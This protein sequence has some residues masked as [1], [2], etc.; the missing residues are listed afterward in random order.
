MQRGNYANG[1]ELVNGNEPQDYVEAY[2][3]FSIVVAMTTD[4]TL[5]SEATKA[6]DALAA[7][8]DVVQISE[9]LRLAKEWT[10]DR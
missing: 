7:K 9:A 2:K 4:A 6:R 8:M 1:V 3:M 5:A 10:A